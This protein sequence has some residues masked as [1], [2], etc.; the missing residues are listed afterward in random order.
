MKMID[1]G[2]I[3][4]TVMFIVIVVVVE[5]KESRFLRSATHHSEQSLNEL[6]LLYSRTT[7][8]LAV[9]NFLVDEENKRH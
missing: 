4:Y 5:E 2:L 7:V 3:L 8:P 9:A 6:L 1:E